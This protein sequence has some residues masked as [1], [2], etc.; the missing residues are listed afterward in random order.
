MCGIAGWVDPAGGWAPWALQVLEIEDGRIVEYH[1]F[2]DPEL[3][4]AFGLP[5]HLLRH[6]EPHPLDPRAA[7]R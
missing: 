2:L 7:R 4:A 1:A 5:E 6:Q 3:F